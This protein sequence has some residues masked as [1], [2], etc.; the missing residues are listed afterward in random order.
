MLALLTTFAIASPQGAPAVAHEVW[1]G[2]H[3]ETVRVLGSCSFAGDIDDC[4]DGNGRPDPSLRARFAASAVGQFKNFKFRSTN[5]LF[6]LEVNVPHGVPFFCFDNSPWFGQIPSKTIVELSTET[7]PR[8]ALFGSTHFEYAEPTGATTTIP[9]KLNATAELDGRTLK[10]EGYGPDPSNEPALAYQMWGWVRL[11]TERPYRLD[12]SGVGWAPSDAVCVR[13][14]GKDRKPLIGSDG[15]EL[16]FVA[17]MIK[18]NILSGAG[19]SNSPSFA[20]LGTDFDVRKA[21]YLEMGRATTSS[22]SFPKIALHR[23]N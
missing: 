11:Q 23:L 5:R 4:T 16:R 14:I 18:S 2:S 13:L 19:E 6:G 15:A 12:L 8:D 20:L 7:F 10:V 17:R 9:L 3:G 21:T 22:I 1:T